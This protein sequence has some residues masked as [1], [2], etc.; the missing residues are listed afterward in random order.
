MMKKKQWAAVVV[1]AAL[2]L[3]SLAGTAVAK[4]PADEAFERIRQVYNVV[5]G[6]HKDGVDTQ[7]FMN[8]AIKGGLEALGDP[9]TNYFPADEYDSFLESLNGNFSGIGAYLEQQGQYVVIS[10]PIKGSP[11]EAAGLETGDRILEVNGT[12]LVGA[13]TDKAV[14]LIR[15]DSGTEVTLKIERTAESRTFTITITRARV[16][17]PEIEYKMLD[18][19][20]GY[21]QLSSFGDDA[22]RDFY[23]AVEALK[24]QG[25]KGLL[26][27]LRQNGGGYLQAA[28]DIASAF[29]PKNQPVVWEIGKGEK[30]SRNSSGQLI[31]LPTVVLV[32]NGSASAS[33]VLAG[34]LQDYGVAPLVG[35]KTFGK[36]TVQQLLSLVNGGGMKVTIAEYVTPK[37][38]HVH[39]VGLSPD[40]VVENPKPAAERTSA[41]TI[42]RLLQSSS[43]GLDVLYLQYRLDDLGYRTD[44]RGFY[45]LATL[46]AVAKFRKDNGLPAGDKVD[47][48]FVSKLNERV[49]EHWKNAPQKDEQ[50]TR[51]WGLVLDKLGN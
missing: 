4:N 45:G 28:V 30:V 5:S 32:D 9:Y 34:A 20:V 37:E 46:D 3:G 27:D 7:K 8:G 31:D 15:G 40:Y 38:R 26:L 33:E 39:G 42:D 41:M 14:S 29:V 17:I 22:V 44:S 24:G 21:I 35:V 1:S 13:T 16:V 36:G 10:S 12:S 23:E 6:W 19:Q 25:A 11:A 48:A 51:A 43:A 49:R 18:S 2:A 47:E 50:L